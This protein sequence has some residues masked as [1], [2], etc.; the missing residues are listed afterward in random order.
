MADLG[1]IG[2][3]LPAIQP[4]NATTPPAAKI[5]RL[6]DSRSFGNRCYSGPSVTIS[7]T[8]KQAGSPAAR[9]VRVYRRSDG[10]LLG[11]TTADPST[12]AYS[13]DCLGNTG[14]VYAIELPE[15]GTTPDL[16]AQILDGITPG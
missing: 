9:T 6:S 13:I 12:G 1:S 7:G 14:E 5:S 3:K 10:A 4:A 2:N 11:T 16:N 8:A 15:T